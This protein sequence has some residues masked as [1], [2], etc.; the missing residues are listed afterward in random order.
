[1]LSQDTQG[2]MTFAQLGLGAAFLEELCISFTERGLP[3]TGK[4][5][6]ETILAKAHS[7]M[8]ASEDDQAFNQA[9]EA[10]R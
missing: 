9:S 10:I 1:M 6:V 3:E 5:S 2:P 8:C 7:L 4:L